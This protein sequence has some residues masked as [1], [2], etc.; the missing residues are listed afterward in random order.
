MILFNN[1]TS[2]NLHFREAL[3]EIG[4]LDGCDRSRIVSL[5]EYA[6][7]A[8]FLG[9]GRSDVKAELAQSREEQRF[10]KVAVQ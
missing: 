10:L 9:R 6:R 5:A 8:E 4:R 7:E 1:Y 3:W 2:A